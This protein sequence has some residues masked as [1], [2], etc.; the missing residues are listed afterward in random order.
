MLISVAALELT[1]DRAPDEP[2]QNV[3]SPALKAV[4][5]GFAM[6]VGFL[7]LDLPI[8]AVLGLGLVA[9]GAQAI[10]G[11]VVYCSIGQRA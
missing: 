10:Y 5:G 2:T 7:P 11:A 1:L 6:I 9:L 3:T 4:T 8:S